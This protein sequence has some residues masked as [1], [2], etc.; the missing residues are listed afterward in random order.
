M[1]GKSESGDNYQHTARP[2]VAM[3]IDHNRDCAVA[4]H[5]HRRAQLIYAARGVITVGSREGRW[6]V[7]PTR[8]VWIPAHTPHW[9]EMRRRA[10]VRI[11]YIENREA[12]SLPKQCHVV[13]V[14][15]LLRELILEAVRIPNRYPP[16]GREARIMR[17]IVDEARLQP[18]LP[19]SLP[20]PRE[21]RALQVARELIK[22]PASTRTLPEWAHLTG[23]SP[24]TL[25]RIFLRETGVTF[26]HWRQQLRLLTG[27]SLLAA[28]EKI[29]AVAL[30]SGYQ[31]ASAFTEAFRKAFGV[32]PSRYFDG[33]SRTV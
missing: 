12:G 32:P 29:L 14:S 22:H 3:A 21:K 27:L 13:T 11:V 2:I 25:A 17:L 9:M 8:A 18:Q 1:Y 4:W 28:S 20:L 10:Q 26:G 16:Q 33:K 7:P 19:V 31:S 30:Y 6:V 23:C 5:S 15:P 24:R